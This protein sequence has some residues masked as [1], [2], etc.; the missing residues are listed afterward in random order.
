MKQTINYLQTVPHSH[1]W[2]NLE[3]LLTFLEAYKN[4]MKLEPHEGKLEDYLIVGLQNS[5]K[6]G[7]DLRKKKKRKKLTKEQKLAKIRTEHG[8]IS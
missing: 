6:E 7:Y 5:K 1:F 3:C 8:V 4:G 2:P